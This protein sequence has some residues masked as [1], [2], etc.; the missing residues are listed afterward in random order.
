MFES[1]LINRQSSKQL[2]I[3]L[4]TD[5]FVPFIIFFCRFT[6]TQTRKELNNCFS[7]KK[8]LF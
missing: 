5:H 4:L 2:R 8:S 7:V 1:K 6:N 3:K